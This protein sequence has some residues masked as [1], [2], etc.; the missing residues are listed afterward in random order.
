[1]KIEVGGICRNCPQSLTHTSTHTPIN[2]L[3]HSFTHQ[4]THSLLHSPTHPLHQDAS[5]HN[6]FFLFVLIENGFNQQLHSRTKKKLS[7]VSPQ[8]HVR[9]LSFSLS[10]FLSSFFLLSFASV[11]FSVSFS[12]LFP[13]FFLFLSFR[14]AFGYKRSQLWCTYKQ[15]AQ[16]G[17]SQTCFP[18]E[19]GP[20]FLFWTLLSHLAKHSACDSVSSPRGEAIERPPTCHPLALES[21]L[22]CGQNIC[23]GRTSPK[24]AIRFDK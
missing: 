21:A 9:T 8:I 17:N 19:V 23:G 15:T 3:I 11:F 18:S 7:A 16:P 1:M 22:V 13:F 5:L 2:S 4:P 10:L 24:S 12:L 6:L 14:C 20:R